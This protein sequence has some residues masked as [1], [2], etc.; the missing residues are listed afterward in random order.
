MR[1]RGLVGGCE[2]GLAATKW[3]GG[4]TGFRLNASNEKASNEKAS[5]PKTS[6]TAV[7]P[8]HNLQIG[9]RVKAMETAR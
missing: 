9:Q 1:P 5:G 3:E 6:R 8:A 4:G 2:T 7:R